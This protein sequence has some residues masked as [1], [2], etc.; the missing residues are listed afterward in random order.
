VLLEKDSATLN[1]RAVDYIYGVDLIRFI[2][3]LSVACFHLTWKSVNQQWGLPFGWV[4]VEVFF[5]I[6]GLVIANSAW[7]STAPRFVVSR[8]LRIYP[9]AWCALPVTC[10]F[11]LLAPAQAYVHHGIGAGWSLRSFIGSITLVGPGHLATAYWTLPIEISFYAVVTLL[12]LMRRFNNVQAWAVVF[13]LWSVPYIAF[14]GMDPRAWS[15]PGLLNFGYSIRNATLVRHGFY[16]GLGMLLWA[17]RQGRLTALGISAFVF[18]LAEAWIEIADRAGDVQNS[19]RHP[20]FFGIPVTS[21]WLSV[22][23]YVAFLVAVA[24]LFLAFAVNARFPV[25]A[26]LR[27]A[28]RL[29]GLTTYPFYLLHESV[30]GCMLEFAERLGVAPGPALLLALCSI[31]A[32]SVAIAAFAEPALRSL[33][34]RSVPLLSPQPRPL[35]V[36]D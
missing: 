6:S 30:G 22:A 20:A 11:L 15:H 17:Y 29:I 1:Q 13:I 33:L 9:A 10:A 27:R 32:L 21:Q 4:G 7:G 2:C 26:G 8:F 3:A 28:V 12:L 5:V 14:L 35:A 31:A 24:G 34:R 19:L 36:C 25:H 23:S 18:A 16:F